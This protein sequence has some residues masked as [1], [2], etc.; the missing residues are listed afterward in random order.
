MLLKIVLKYMDIC[1]VKIYV[2]QKVNKVK[3]KGHSCSILLYS[4]ILTTEM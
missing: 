3:A 4:F 2:N 1:N